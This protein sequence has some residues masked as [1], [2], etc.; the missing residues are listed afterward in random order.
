ML[1]APPH[2]IWRPVLAA[3]LALMVSSTAFA[4]QQYILSVPGR[5][6]LTSQATVQANQL[7]IV[8]AQGQRHTYTRQQRFD[9]PDRKYL[10]F[11]SQQA[12]QFIRWPVSG[13][14][15]M[16]I[17]GPNGRNWKQSKQQIRAVGGAANPGGVPRMV[18]KPIIPGQIPNL[19]VGQQRR[20]R[21]GPPNVTFLPAGND[22]LNVGYIDGRGQ[23]RLFSGMR[24]RWQPVTI[25]Q[26][27]NLVPGAPLALLPAGQGQ[28]PALFTVSNRGQLLQL[29]GQRQRPVLNNIAFRPGGHLAFP[30]PTQTR[31]G[32]AIDAQGRLIRFDVS[33]GSH[34]WIDQQPNR[35]APGGPLA[36]VLGVNNL[37]RVPN[38]DVF[39]VDAGGSLLHYPLG[40]RGPAPARLITRGFAPSAPIQV[41]RDRNGVL[42]LAGIDARG[43]LQLLTQR[44][45]RWAANLVTRTRFTPGAPVELVDTGNGLVLSS[46]AGNGE[47]H[48]WAQSP[49]G[50]W[51]DDTLSRGFAAGT[52]VAFHPQSQTGFGIDATGRLVASGLWD[53]GWHSHLLLPEY[54]LSPRL[55]SRQVVPN[56][57]LPPARVLFQNPS[58]EEVVM[59]LD[60]ALSPRGPTQHK[61]PAGGAL[62][63]TIPRDPGGVL[64]ERYAVFGPGGWVERVDRLPLPAAPQHT[65]VVWANRT[66]YSYIDKKGVSV[67]P[68]F[69][70]KS[71]VSLGVFELPPGELLRDGEQI[72]VYGEAVARRNPGAAAW[73]GPPA[74][75][76][77]V[78]VHGKRGAPGPV[79][80][81]ATEN[82]PRPNVPQ[83]PAEDRPTVP[84]PDP[85]PPR[86]SGGPLI[87]P[88]P[89]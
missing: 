23:P 4:Q 80:P 7:V 71:H 84:T 74:G 41:V 81:F 69:D 15:S 17:G 13:T 50:S 11:Y 18:R 73:F 48:R 32:F 14:G 60:N 3:L 26:S 40:L 53:G 44:Q 22:R 65:V 8:D 46:V 45:G 76:P 89:Q 70:L 6:D 56:R 66:T 24:D 37:G 61:I 77:E 87:P 62:N 75:G 47:W 29:Y 83:Q 5:R 52:P 12:G 85:A 78:V 79:V 16:L 55:L 88:L 25:A 34:Q 28:S 49:A 20:R 27:Q 9:S 21:L 38:Y 67:L 31:D 54:D 30:A 2:H 51:Q 1:H 35:F 68:D 72:D 39:A 57:P 86:E 42:H 82:N 43:Q 33:A 59:Q 58:R 10:G 63:L 19:G 36:A 64:E